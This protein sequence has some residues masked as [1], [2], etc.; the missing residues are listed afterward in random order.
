MKTL[1]ELMAEATALPWHVETDSAEWQYVNSLEGMVVKPP[2]GGLAGGD[3]ETIANSAL[4]VHC[5]NTYGDL[6][7]ALKACMAIPD[8]QC[9]HTR[10]NSGCVCCKTKAALELANNVKGSE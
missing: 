8:N 9:G 2:I 5:V 3:R 10:F 4:I 1:K 7:E 6:V